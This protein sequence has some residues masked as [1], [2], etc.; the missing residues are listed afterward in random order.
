M[1]SGWTR[2]LLEQY[3]FPFEV[4]FAKALDTGDVASKFD[5]LIFPDGAIPM[6]DN[7]GGGQPNA[8][9]IPAEFHDWLGTVTISRTV[10]ELKKFVE[11]G[12]TLLAIGSSTSIGYHFALPI[13]NALVERSATTGVAMPLAPGQFI[14]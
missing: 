11:T 14:L 7:S 4:V 9:S 10:P 13:C 3:E 1:A 8:T 12:G 5:V 2:W 6:R